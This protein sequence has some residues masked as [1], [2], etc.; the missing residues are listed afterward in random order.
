M[1]SKSILLEKYEVGRLLGQGTFA[2]VYLAK[3][4]KSGQTVAIKAFDKE[5]VFKVG[6]TEQIKREI[7]VMKMV[8]HPNIIKLYEV[9]ATKK[10]IY[11]AMEYAKGG[12]LFQKIAKGGRVKEEIAHRYFRQL[13]DAVDFCHSRG[14][15]HR[16]LKLENLLLDEEDNLKVTDFGLSALIRLEQPGGLLHTTCGTPAYVAPEVLSKKG[17]DGAKTDIWSCGVILFVL[18]A[19]YLPFHDSNLMEM[20]KKIQKGEFKCPS[21]F[22]SRLKKLLHKILDPDPSTR[23][24][25][26]G[27]KG[28]S[29]YRKGFDRDQVPKEKKIKENA[30][31]VKEKREKMKVASMNAFDI[32]SLSSGFDLS[33]F[34]VEREN[35]NETWFTSRQPVSVLVSRLEELGKKLKLRVR[36]KENGVVKMTTRNGGRKGVVEIDAEIFQIDCSSYMVEIKKSNGDT[37][38]YQKILKEEIRPGLKDIIW[39]WQGDKLE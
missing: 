10:K 16:D 12:E 22:S 11:F 1:E 21:W 26:E 29:W 3:N 13:I 28:M 36:K 4:L 33:G 15:Y 23:L 38:E 25:V 14:I 5:K 19:G 37:L 34:F 9:M 17:Y 20:Y 30:T 27:I 32:I 24:T 18:V 2:K 8:N 6:L 39:T 7:S 35:R 31:V